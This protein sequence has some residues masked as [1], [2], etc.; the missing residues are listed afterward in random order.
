LGS[1]SQS[2]SANQLPETWNV[3]NRVE[4]W[5]T[6]DGNNSGASLPI[7]SVE[8]IYRGVLVSE[9]CLDRSNFVGRNAQ[10][11]RIGLQFVQ[12]L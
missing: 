1:L 5:L 8:P 9:S 10:L 11:I 6:G 7:G 2:N 12:Q 3:P 4:P